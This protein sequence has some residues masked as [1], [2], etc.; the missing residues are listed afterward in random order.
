MTSRIRGVFLFRESAFNICFFNFYLIYESVFLSYHERIH[1]VFRSYIDC[2]PPAMIIISCYSVALHRLTPYVPGLRTGLWF[3]PAEAGPVAYSSSSNKTSSASRPNI[4]PA[5]TVPCSSLLS[6]KRKPKARAS[7]ACIF[8]TVQLKL[9][10][11]S[12]SAS[13]S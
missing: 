4:D 6:Q 10:N 3:N 2:L 1:R 5:Y 7:C 8:W 11:S 13:K 12:Q 9:P